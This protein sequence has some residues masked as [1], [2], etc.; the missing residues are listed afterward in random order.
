MTLS[1]QLD[2]VFIFLALLLLAGYTIFTY[3]VTIPELRLSKKIALIVIR[4]LVILTLFLMM[5]EPLLTISHKKDVNPINYIFVD[6]SKSQKV[7]EG[8][9][10]SLGKA[11]ISKL[12]KMSHSS[13]KLFSFGNGF[14]E[15]K[16]DDAS[17]FSYMEPAT[18]FSSVFT[19]LQKENEIASV[20][21]ISDGIITQG[22]TPVYQAEKLNVPIFTIG[23]G[24]ST[25]K[26]DLILDNVLH[27]EYLYSGI[28]TPLKVR[29]TQHGFDGTQTVLSLF[30]DGVLRTTKPVSFSSESEQ[31]V[32][33]VY[34][35]TSP[36]EKKLKV[37]LT[38]LPGEF[39]YENN[40]TSVFV[41]ILDS[42]LNIVLLAGAPSTD[43]T[44]FKNTLEADTNNAVQTFTQITSN[45]YLERKSPEK[46][47]EKVDVLYLLNF[48]SNVTPPPLV[49]KI[50]K[51]IREKNIPYFFE[52]SSS[53]DASKL[54]LLDTE[55]P[56]IYKKSDN[57][58]SEVQPVVEDD[59][60]RNPLIQYNGKD[61]LNEWNN[62][63]PVFHPN[64]NC[65][66]K[67]EAE[68]IAKLKMNTIKL[69]TPLIISRRLGSK[70]GIAVLASDIW[71]WKLQ[72]APSQVDLFDR[73]V[74]NANK[75]LH[76]ADQ[77]KQV[78][79]KTD[80]KFY[81]LGE[82]VFFTAEVFDEGFNPVNDAEIKCT[83]KS[84]DDERTV[85]FTSAGNGFYQGVI[86]DLPK[87]DFIFNGEAFLSNHSLGK[88][89]GRFS[90]GEVDYELQQT[91]MNADM[92]QLLAKDTKGK[93]YYNTVGDFFQRLQS[94]SERSKKIDVETSQYQL[95]DNQY[96]LFILILLFSVEW[97]IRKQDGLL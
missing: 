38:N 15:I 23:I 25:T 30:E 78:T 26:K 97:I 29:I 51:L 17:N 34:K 14:R 86:N 94:I 10:S 8:K 43:V 16:Q 85:T 84:K 11:I 66:A 79:I 41:K 22:T 57:S 87:E 18:N 81:S 54:H 60:A 73:F 24:D 96:L 58:I 20:S 49:E 93:F 53:V 65:Q 6:N 28:E 4:V 88:D 63:P 61:V 83:I 72:I 59:A 50:A 64:W 36:G 82:K 95:W 75:W 1:F 52:L 68:V 67:P 46:A 35:P 90:I 39:T 7:F 3:R 77:Q 37:T 76:A 62:L 2:W 13:Y 33:L 27:N 45:Q 5:F 71:K 12:K 74:N 48:P 56:F 91:T 19:F 40:R 42:K 69:A 89:E 44:F 47:L 31:N 92:L 70:R 9:T 32:D 55:L 21:I 80:K